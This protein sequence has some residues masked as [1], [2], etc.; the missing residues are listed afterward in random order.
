MFWNSL[1]R[2]GKLGDT[3]ESDMEM[4]VAIHN[5][6]NEGTWGK[7]LEWEGVVG[8]EGGKAELVSSST[9]YCTVLY[10]TG[11]IMYLV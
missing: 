11:E 8:E 7:V 5:S 4:V 1:A 6:M 10:C 9:V 2:K 3:K